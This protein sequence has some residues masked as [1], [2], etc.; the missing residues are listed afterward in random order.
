ML[1]FDIKLIFNN[2]WYKIFRHLVNVRL[3]NG[4][5][6]TYIKSDVLLAQNKDTFMASR[7]RSVCH[8]ILR[9]EDT[10]TQTTV[11][12]SVPSLSTITH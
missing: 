11:G 9:S 5:V 1:K 12:K 8:T 6:K 4:Y 10:T 3:N 2:I 7:L